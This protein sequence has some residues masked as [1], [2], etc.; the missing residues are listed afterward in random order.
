MA[1][2]LAGDAMIR[3]LHVLTATGAMRAWFTI[4]V[5]IAGFGAALGLTIGY[6]AR[7]VHRSDQQWC[8]LLRGIDQPLPSGTPITKRTRDF[9]HNVH[10]LR[11]RKGC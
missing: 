5:L 6:T 4:V 3:Q 11:V 8:E 2:D 10:V 1:S 9:A 7:A